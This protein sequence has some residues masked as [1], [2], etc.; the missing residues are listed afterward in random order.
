MANPD[1]WH[2]RW[3]QETQ[4]TLTLSEEKGDLTDVVVSL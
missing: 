3:L 1:L 4:S 2:D